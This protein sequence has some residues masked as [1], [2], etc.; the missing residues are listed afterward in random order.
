MMSLEALSG[1][2]VGDTLGLSVAGAI[3]D[4]VGVQSATPSTISSIN[5]EASILRHFS[6]KNALTER[7]DKAS[8]RRRRTLF[9]TTIPFNVSVALAAGDGMAEG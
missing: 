3:G 7:L 5:V 1:S 4:A 9:V 6:H 2:P 8:W